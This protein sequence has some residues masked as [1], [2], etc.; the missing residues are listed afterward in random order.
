VV[1]VPRG[2]SPDTV[3]KLPGDKEATLA[4]D[5]HTFEALVPPR[6]ESAHALRKAEWLWVAQDRLAVGVLLRLTVF[7]HDRSAV[8][9][10]GIE[11]A[12]VGDQPA[13]V[14]DFIELIG[15]GLSAGADLDVFV[16]ECEGRLHHSFHNRDA[17]RKFDADDG[18]GSARGSESRRGALHPGRGSGRWFRG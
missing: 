1:G 17:G 11:L 15:L 12:A 16:A 7:V 14:C 6:N 18:G 13:G 3:C 2:Y 4:A 8:I 9:E 5:F 10:G